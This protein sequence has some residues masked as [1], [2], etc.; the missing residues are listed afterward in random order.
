[1]NPTSASSQ[2]Q[3]GAVV[4]VEDDGGLRQA[5]A[6]LLEVAG[7]QV[8]AF[9]SAEA[10]LQARFSPTAC[11]VCDVRLP[12]LSGFA[13][14]ERLRQYGAA[15]PV[16]FITGHDEPV[17]RRRAEALGAA[18]YL[19]KPFPGTELVIAINSAI[20]ARVAPTTEEGRQ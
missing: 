14:Y 19:I 3:A 1:M 16:I 9:D 6:R 4:V 5:V 2:R 17:T 13:L 11:L 15:P 18:A 10:W 8:R 12:G 20:H 7:F